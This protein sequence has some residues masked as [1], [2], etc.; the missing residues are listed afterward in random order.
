MPNLADA[1]LG[2][3]DISLSSPTAIAARQSPNPKSSY[4]DW[5]AEVKN[6]N[7][8]EN[9]DGAVATD[10]VVLTA[11]V[12]GICV[13]VAVSI[14]GGLTQASEN[15]IVAIAATDPGESPTATGQ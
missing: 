9:E 12:V 2:G 8:V 14:G 7:F 6:A 5:L 11:L 3:V 10:W 1:A 4:Q 13:A 15:L